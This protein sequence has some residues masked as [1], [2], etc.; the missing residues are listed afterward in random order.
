[1]MQPIWRNI[2]KHTIEKSPIN[3][4]NQ[5]DYELGMAMRMQEYAVHADYAHICKYVDADENLIHIIHI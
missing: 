1:M 3:Q 2:W 5:C 4:C